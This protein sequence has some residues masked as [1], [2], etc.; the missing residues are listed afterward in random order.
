MLPSP[1]FVFFVHLRQFPSQLL[2]AL[3]LRAATTVSALLALALFWGR[4]R[5]LRARRASER[6]RKR[7]GDGEDHAFGG[8]SKSRRALVFFSVLA[9]HLLVCRELGFLYRRAYHGPVHRLEQERGVRGGGGRESRS[10]ERSSPA[11]AR[12][13]SASATK[14]ARRFFF[15]FFQ[16]DEA[17]FRPPLC[18]LFEPFSTSSRTSSSSFSEREGEGAI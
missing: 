4:E 8:G 17:R 9:V 7:A 13:S 18:R 16:R 5:A 6:W 1:L 2:R 10:A 11:D 14:R 3:S 15:F 12:L